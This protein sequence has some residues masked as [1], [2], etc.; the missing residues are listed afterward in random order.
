MLRA[1]SGVDARPLQF[2][3]SRARSLRDGFYRGN[4]TLHDPRAVLE[5]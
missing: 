1:E 2:A 5:L 4:C 3:S